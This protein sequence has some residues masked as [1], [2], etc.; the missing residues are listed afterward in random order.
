MLPHHPDSK[1]CSQCVPGCQRHK[2]TLHLLVP[3]TN[4]IT[5]LKAVVQATSYSVAA[6]SGLAQSPYSNPISLIIHITISRLRRDSGLGQ[7]NWLSRQELQAGRRHWLMLQ[8]FSSRT[9]F[10]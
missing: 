6:L 5:C 10:G 3:N 7:D 2:R 1:S 4:L 9:E 8:L